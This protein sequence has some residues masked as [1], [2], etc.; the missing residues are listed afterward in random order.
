MKKSDKHAA[1]CLCG[2]VQ[3]KTGPFKGGMAAC[4]CSMCRKW[5]GG[6][7]MVVD[8]GSE[9]EMDGAEHV[10]LFDSSE[11]AQ[12]GFCKHCGTHLF[13]RLKGNQQYQVPIGLFDDNPQVRFG[14][15]VFIDEKPGY[16]TFADQ[17]SNM[18]GAEVVAKYA[19]SQQ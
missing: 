5:G 8:C 2:A 17:T 4:H 3:L 15:Q 1:R 16:Y 12:R 9:V 18:T 19:P 10:A 6:P 11:W 7:F 14:L 13:Y